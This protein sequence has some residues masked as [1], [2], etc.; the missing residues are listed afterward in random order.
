MQLDRPVCSNVNSTK[1]SSGFRELSEEMYME[2]I[3]EVSCNIFRDR[4]SARR[5]SGFKYRRLKE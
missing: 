4:D 2:Q 5:N 1:C 3:V